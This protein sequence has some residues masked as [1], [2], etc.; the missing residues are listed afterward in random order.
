MNRTLVRSTN[1]AAIEVSAQ[2]ERA[3]G[4]SRRAIPHA[5]LDSVDDHVA[6]QIQ[7]PSPNPVMSVVFEI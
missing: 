1:G 6:S 3:A 7:V 4:P 5:S 2:V